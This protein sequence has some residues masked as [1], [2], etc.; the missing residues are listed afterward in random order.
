[1]WWRFRIKRFYNNCILF[2]LTIF[3]KRTLEGY[4][5]CFL[6][7][8]KG[9]WNVYNQ[10]YFT[11]GFIQYFT[12]ILG[13]RILFLFHYASWRVRVVNSR[14]T[15]FFV[16]G[17]LLDLSLILHCRILFGFQIWFC[18]N[19]YLKYTK[20]KKIVSYSNFALWWQIFRI[21]DSHKK[22][23]TYRDLLMHMH[24][25]KPKSVWGY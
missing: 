25:Q 14:H 18:T 9:L 11:I 23:N 22:L 21:F 24:V 20:F 1:M 2:S 17:N 12:F 15:L 6:F 13:I 19:I 4:I 16:C 5:R 10:M 7:M 8:I 3:L